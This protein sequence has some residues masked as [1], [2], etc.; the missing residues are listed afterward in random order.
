MLQVSAQVIG[1][2]TAITVGGLQ[3]QFELNV[4]IPLMARNLLQSIHLLS[5]DERA[6]RREVRRGDRGQP[7]GLRALGRGHA[8]RRHRA[9]PVHRLRQGGGDRQGGG[10]QRAH[11]ARGRARPR[12]RGVDARRGARPAQDRRGIIGVV[13]R[14]RG[15]LR[16]GPARRGPCGGA[17]AAAAV[18]RRGRAV[19]VLRAAVRRGE[20]T[21]DRRAGRA[22]AP[23]GAGARRRRSSGSSTSRRRSAP[24]RARAGLAVLEVPLMVL[25]AAARRRPPRRRPRAAARAR[26]PAARAPRGRWPSSPSAAGA[27]PG[28]ASATPRVARR[29]PLGARR[30]ARAAGRPGLTVTY[31]AEDASG[32][33]AVGSHQPVGD[34]TEVVGIATLPTHARRGLATAVTAALVA[35]ARARRRRGRVPVGR[36]RRRR[37][38]VLPARLRARR[39]RRPRRG[40][41]VKLSA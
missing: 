6:V 7:R 36:Q 15:L 29:P 27:A 17:R 11:A 12:G 37:A 1:N 19:A 18:R 13:A 9:E 20:V 31:V 40:G 10:G 5:T 34:V 38:P 26:R 39:D 25:D 23:V 32:V 3:G 28:R 33:V 41:R 4:R 8:R 30:R 22:L 14:D 16:R 2:D 35:D 24:R 21:R